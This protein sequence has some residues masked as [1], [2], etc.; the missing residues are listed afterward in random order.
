MTPSTNES[1]SRSMV[2]QCAIDCLESTAKMQE[3][4]D[5]AGKVEKENV[6]LKDQAL[7]Y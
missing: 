2:R 7:C 1:R 5:R 6:T 4:E 3:M